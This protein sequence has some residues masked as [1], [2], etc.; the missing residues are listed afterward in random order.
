MLGALWIPDAG[1]VKTSLVATSMRQIAD[2]TGRVTSVANT[3]V[4]DIETA[5]ARA[6]AVLT[7]NPEMPRVECNQV[8]ICTNIWAPV[9]CQKLGINMPLF[10]GQHQYIYTHPVEALQ[11]LDDIEI[12][13]PMTAMDD[14]SIYFRQHFDHIGI[15]S[16]H[17]KA[18][19]YGGELGW[20]FYAP[21]NYGARLWDTLWEAGQD[22]GMHAT[23]VGALLSLRLEKG[24]RLYGADMH[25]EHNP[26]ETGLG[27]L[28][29]FEKGNFIG[30][31]AVLALRDQPLKRK[32]VTLTFD[33]PKTVLFGFEPIL[34][35]D[36]VVGH[37]ASG[38][39]GYNVGK[40]VA[41]AWVPAELAPVGTEIQVQCTGVRYPG[42]VAPDVLFDSSMKRLR[43]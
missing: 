1:V 33:D 12:N 27:W 41:L 13:I 6:R 28:V 16:Y 14:I 35:G 34:V 31:D 43:A 20:E 26:F 42:V 3:L 25:M 10:P 9:L 40:F 11:G 4:T 23:G 39:Y 24:Y 22:L 15:G 32:L 36:E 21:A 29:D 17:H 30:R 5:D 8:V 37:I 18:L 19:S 2:R 38:N 7:D